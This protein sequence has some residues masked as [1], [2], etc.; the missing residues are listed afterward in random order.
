MVPRPPS[1]TLF[2]TRRSSDLLSGASVLVLEILG[3]RVLAPYYG[4]SLFLWST[5][6]AVTLAALAA[7]YAL[8][9]DRKST[10][11][12]SSHSSISYAVF[13]LKKK[14]ARCPDPSAFYL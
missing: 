2:P 13:C 11:L 3:T 4:V 5:L 6:I 10:R 9:G 8:G 14:N 7:G 1:S 12:N